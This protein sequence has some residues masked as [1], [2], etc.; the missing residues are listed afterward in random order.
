MA[1]SNSFVAD[2]PILSDEQLE[3]LYLWGTSCCDKFDVRMNGD[4]GM[5]VVALRKKDGTVRDHQRLLRTNL[6]HWGVELPHKQAGWLRLLP[7]DSIASA[8]PGRV[9]TAPVAAEPPIS[10]QPAP[11]AAKP[12]AARVALRLPPNLLTPCGEHARP[13]EVQARLCCAA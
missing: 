4:M 1:R 3:K 6:I 8:A 10:S 11:P 2:L 5:T 13:I 7:H 12:P 9:G